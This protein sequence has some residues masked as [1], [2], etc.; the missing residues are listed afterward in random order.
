MHH[1]SCRKA[2]M[3]SAAGCSDRQPKRGTNLSPEDL[4][5]L[6]K[7]LGAGVDPKLGF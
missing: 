5:R 4:K 3:K 2:R 6:E 1:K 7:R